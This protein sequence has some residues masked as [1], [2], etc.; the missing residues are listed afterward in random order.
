[1]H[2]I[3]RDAYV[4]IDCASYCVIAVSVN[5]PHG[6]EEEEAGLAHDSHYHTHTYTCIKR[7]FM[8][9]RDLKKAGSGLPG[10]LFELK[11]CIQ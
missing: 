1:M 7:E 3:Y 9:T 11:N 2:N 4:C 6:R 10:V 8:F 5:I